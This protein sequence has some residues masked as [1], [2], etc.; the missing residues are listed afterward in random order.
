MSMKNL[1]RSAAQYIGNDV[2]RQQAR[3]V[4]VFLPAVLFVGSIIGPYAQAQA[5]IVIDN[6]RPIW[7]PEQSLRLGETPALVIGTQPGEMYEFYRVAGTA[8]LSDGRIVV[9]DGGSRSLRFFDQ[10]G[11]FLNSVGGQGGG[12]GEFQNLLSFSVMPGDTLV[13]GDMRTLSYFTGSGQY[14]DRHGSLN[15]EMRTATV[16]R[17][18]LVSLDGS[19]T[20][21]VAAMPLRPQPGSD[22]IWVDSVPV[23]IVD[24]RNEEIRALGNLPSKELTLAGSQPR[25]PWFGATMT[26]ASDGDLFYVGIGTDYAIRVYT[27]E[28]HLKQII[29]RAWTPVRVTNADIDEYVR[30]WGK[31]WIRSTGQEAE[32]ERRS[33]RGDPYAETV[34]AFSQFIVDQVGRLWVR[35]AN[36]ADAPGAGQLNTTPLVPSV[37][38][39]FDREGR[40]LGDVTMPARFQPRDIGGD[41]VL[42]TAM[43]EDDVQTIAV[44]ELESLAGGP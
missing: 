38:S 19:G 5:P 31:R 6:P 39:V 11:T 36:L 2:K 22:A 35:E 34:P 41:Y 12:P 4:D 23:S 28:G 40:W 7:A 43:D 9:A 3:G 27:V 32:A 21:V 8:R 14:L 20:R 44:Y 42:G 18:V 10:A 1:V 15:G 30:E 25:P 37:W 16:M 13:A 24:G 17:I 26:Y 29:R 33:L